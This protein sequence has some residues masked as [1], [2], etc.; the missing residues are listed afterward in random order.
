MKSPSVGR[1]L[2]DAGRRL[3]GAGRAVCEEDHAGPKCRQSFRLNLYRE[4]VTPHPDRI[5]RCDPTSPAGGEV[6][7]VHASRF[8]FQTAKTR[9][10]SKSSFRGDAKHRTRNLEIPGLVLRTHPAMT[11]TRHNSAFPRRDAP[12]SLRN[13]FD[14]FLRALPGDRALL[15]PSSAL[16][17]ANLTPASRRQDH[18]TSPSAIRRPRQKRRPRPPHPVPNVRDDRETPLQRDRT[19]GVMDLIWVW[20][21]A[22]YFCRGGLDDPNHVDSSR[23]NRL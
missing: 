23:Q 21:E 20:R 1:E 3:G 5:C 18:T 14:G 15:S 17:S 11:K 6:T 9:G 16:P 10:A 12:E 2:A 22:K 4:S 13:G 19:A 7:R 8:D